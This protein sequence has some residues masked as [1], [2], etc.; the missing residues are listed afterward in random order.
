MTCVYGP[1][2]G[3]A[4]TGASLG[5]AGQPLQSNLGAQGSVKDCLQK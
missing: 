4:D 5:F 1:I 2:A 3:E